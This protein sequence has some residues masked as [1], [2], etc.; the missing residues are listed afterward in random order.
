MWNAL[1]G[2]IDAVKLLIRYN[3]DV[4]AVNEPVSNIGAAFLII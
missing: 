4:H 2:K 3:A 1:L